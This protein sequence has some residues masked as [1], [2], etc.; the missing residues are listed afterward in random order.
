M[1]AY[2]VP[3]A[4]AASIGAAPMAFAATAHN[5]TGAIK[6]YDAKAHSITLADGTTYKLPTKFKASDLKVGEKVEVSWVMK[7]DRHDA[8]QVRI[9][10]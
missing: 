10:K 9:L 6:A 2:L 7:G 1:R 4:L 8:T 5:S 3:L